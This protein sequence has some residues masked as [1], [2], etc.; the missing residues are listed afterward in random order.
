MEFNQLDQWLMGLGVHQPG[1]RVVLLIFT[2]VL[3]TG[4]VNLILGS[5]FRTL[6]TQLEKTKNLWDDTLLESARPPAKLFVWVMG[7]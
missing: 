1:L 5:V 2:V 3:I 4:V 7:L 6:G